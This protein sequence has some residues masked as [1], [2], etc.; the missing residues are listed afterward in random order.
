MTTIR[1]IAVTALLSMASVSA[2]AFPVIN[3]GTIETSSGTPA[4]ATPWLTATFSTV[5]ATTVNLTLS[6]TN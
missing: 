3:F 4:G 5:N 6:A 1:K 2:F